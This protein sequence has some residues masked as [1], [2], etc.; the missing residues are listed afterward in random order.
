MTRKVNN[1]SFMNMVMAI[2][3]RIVGEDNSSII[4]KS[5]EVLNYITILYRIVNA[6]YAGIS[7]HA[8]YLCQVCP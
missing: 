3:Y 5:L 4:D 8:P 7:N 6:K 2:P 1:T